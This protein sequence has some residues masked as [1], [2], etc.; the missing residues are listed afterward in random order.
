MKRW[1]AEPRSIKIRMLTVAIARPSGTIIAFDQI[2]D[3][4]RAL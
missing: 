4:G 1:V 2:R 3:T